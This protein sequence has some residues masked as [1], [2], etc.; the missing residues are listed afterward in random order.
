MLGLRG[1]DWFLVGANLVVRFSS[2][3]AMDSRQLTVKNSATLMRNG[4]P[5]FVVGSLHPSKMG[6]NGK[7]WDIDSLGDVKYHEIGWLASVQLYVGRIIIVGYNQN[8]I[9]ECYLRRNGATIVGESPD[10]DI[11]ADF[12]MIVKY[13][14]APLY[15]FCRSIQQNIP[16]VKVPRL[17]FGNMSREACQYIFK[18]CFIDENFI[19]DDMSMKRVPFSDPVGNQLMYSPLLVSRDIAL[20]LSAKPAIKL[21]KVGCLPFRIVE[22]HRPCLFIP[23]LYMVKENFHQYRFDRIHDLPWYE[24]LAVI[25]YM[26]SI[27]HCRVFSLK[28]LCDSTV[29]VSIGATSSDIRNLD[30]SYPFRLV[31]SGILMESIVTKGDKHCGLMPCVMTAALYDKLI[32][33]VSLIADCS[34]VR[35]VVSAGS[36]L[37]LLELLSQRYFPNEVYTVTDMIDSL[38]DNRSIY[39]GPIPP[40]G[41]VWCDLDNVFP[42]GDFQC[43]I[44]MPSAK[45]ANVP[46]QLLQK[47][48][49]EWYYSRDNKALQDQVNNH[50][51]MF[52]SKMLVRDVDSYMSI[53]LFSVS[54]C[55]NDR[56]LPIEILKNSEGPCMM[57]LP[58]KWPID[59]PSLHIRRIN[60]GEK[61]YL[62]SSEGKVYEDHCYEIFEFYNYGYVYQM[63]D[64]YVLAK[65][66]GCMTLP[67]YEAS[68][69]YSGLWFVVTNVN[70]GSYFQDWVT[71]QSLF[72]RII[73]AEMRN[74]AGLSRQDFYKIRK[75]LVLGT[76]PDIEPD[77]YY[78]FAY[79]FKSKRYVADSSGHMLDL[80]VTSHFLVICMHRQMNMIASNVMSNCHVP[81]VMKDFE[82]LCSQQLVAELSWLEPRV[83][84]HSYHEF[85][86]SA[87]IYPE[88]MKQ[89][90]DIEG[91][92]ESRAYVLTKLK[93]IAHLYESFLTSVPL[94]VLA[95]RNAKQ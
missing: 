60:D 32:R 26:I 37:H 93:H 1:R 77:D 73:P 13:G 48:Q 69:P 68:D 39:I 24:S 29:P 43:I 20:S 42:V 53:G 79:R 58:R 41:E 46:V 11:N 40:A 63:R 50:K 89:T 72:M 64:I 90:F 80:L 12:D 91:H 49:T 81:G 16:E 34:Y 4:I 28:Y 18:R 83:L 54:N 66:F 75:E 9:L 27:S 67:G 92:M 62:I 44:I 86:A 10:A 71:T 5:S 8:S 74:S 76:Y 23:N 84:W 85:A 17:Q 87:W 3:K 70:L 95:S 52:I 88:F 61:Q 14:A 7:L 56:N 51:T 47:L 30:P 65:K 38:L 94:G 35:L 45:P 31:G 57:L 19:I 15:S 82:H 36:S 55:S 2:I 78:D 22:F 25:R 59:Y 21:L 6:V 33:R